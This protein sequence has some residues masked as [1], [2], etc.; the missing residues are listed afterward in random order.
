M[1]AVITIERRLQLDLREITQ[2]Y[3]NKGFTLLRSEG[4]PNELRKGKKVLILKKGIWIEL[5]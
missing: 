1:D 4:T 5:Q 2:R 3:L